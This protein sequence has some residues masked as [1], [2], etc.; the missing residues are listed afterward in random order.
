[1]TNQV[2]KTNCKAY[3]HIL[4][5]VSIDQDLHLYSQ[6]TGPLN[7]S[8]FEP[9]THQISLICISINIL[10]PWLPW[11]HVFAGEAYFLTPFSY[12]AIKS[13]RGLL[14][15]IDLVLM[16]ASVFRCRS[17]PLAF[18]GIK[19]NTGPLIC[20]SLLQPQACL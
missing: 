12:S 4:I 5:L 13:I 16:K 11:H 6:C 8:A 15:T 10:H 18:G 17:R 2:Y 7:L 14:A 1:M 19:R 20:L 9:E 3:S